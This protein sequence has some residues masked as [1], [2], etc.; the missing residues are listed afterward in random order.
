MTSGSGIGGRLLASFPVDVRNGGGIRVDK[1]G[2]A[3]RI[4]LD[5]RQTQRLTTIPAGGLVPVQDPLTG[6]IGALP[7]TALPTAQTG[8][9]TQT[10]AKL[11]TMPART[12]K[13][14]LLNSTAPP[15]DV[16][17]TQVL[18]ALGITSGG[19]VAT[20]A[21]NVSVV[22]P[23]SQGYTNVQ[24]AITSIEGRIGSGNGAI[25]SN[26]IGDATPTGKAVLTGN[27]TQGR[28]ALGLGTSSVL[29]VGV[30]GGVPSY[31]DPRFNTTVGSVT[32][33]KITDASAAGRSVLTG[34]PAQGRTALGVDKLFDATKVNSDPPPWTTGRTIYDRVRVEVGSPDANFW[35]A[36]PGRLGCVSAVTGVLS[37]PAEANQATDGGNPTIIISAGV[38]GL[39]QTFSTN[40][41]GVGVFGM[42][43]VG[44][45]N[46]RVWGANF[47]TS[48]VREPEVRAP[49]AVP[50]PAQIN[51]IEVDCTWVQP[52]NAVAGSNQLGISIPAEF[53]GGRPDGNA[54]MIGSERY[55]DFGW[56]NLV[57]A[58]HGS[59][60]RFA[61]LGMS[62]GPSQAGSSGSMGI[63]WISSSG[64]Q[65]TSTSDTN[66]YH[67][68]YL[69][70]A[71]GGDFVFQPDK[72]GG[73]A[74]L[75]VGNGDLS[76]VHSIHP[77]NGFVGA[78]AT[79]G[80]INVTGNANIN[81]TAS[82]SVVQTGNV[83][84]SGDGVFGGNLNVNGQFRTT[85]MTYQ[86]TQVQ[87]SPTGV[88][89]GNAKALIIIP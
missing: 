44:V 28:S 59:A 50:H 27:P 85:N 58:N 26:S 88:L 74:S 69:E 46:G 72:F 43:R 12:F 15:Q 16:N 14:N 79:L 6:L 71:P 41:T 32:S 48:N 83:S 55:G 76:Q 73:Q 51:G 68:S 18:E 75:T 34:T 66:Q 57:G 10:N 70:I 24:G 13:A 61:Q 36:V 17:F 9:G 67:H 56:K 2:L 1:Q 21:T 31:D 78:R 86:G 42:A 82:S 80:T 11:A 25:T 63:Y 29:N 39:C 64:G 49:G 77:V 81:G 87:L 4:A 53:Y 84:A 65:K 19:S 30:S 5:I 23:G 89:P 8:D 37:L 33:D 62:K 3:T 52:S 40:Q 35:P 47:V 45:D 20:T 60:D 38:M 22:P 54:D 7:V